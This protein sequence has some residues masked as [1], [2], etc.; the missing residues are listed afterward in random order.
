MKIK[1]LKNVV[2]PQEVWE[3]RCD[4]CGPERIGFA[5][6]HFLVG[7]EVDPD[8]PRETINL[9]NLTFKEDFEIIEFP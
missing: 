5:D 4:C 2:A 9:S 6:V 3:T 8:S 1:F 7:E